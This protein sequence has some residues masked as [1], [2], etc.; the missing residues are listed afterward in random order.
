[1]YEIPLKTLYIILPDE[2][3]S[4]CSLLLTQSTPTLYSKH[5]E[6]SSSIIC[7]IGSGIV[8]IV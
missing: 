3:I 7:F 1:M 2:Y 5:A 6:V 4:S 8:I